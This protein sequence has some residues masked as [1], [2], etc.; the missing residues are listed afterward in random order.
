MY[1]PWTNR[2]FHGHQSGPRQWTRISDLEF[3]NSNFEVRNPQSAIR[4]SCLS[5][6]ELEALARALLSVLLSLFD[7]RI[8][9][10]QAGLL[11]SRAQVR[12]ELDQRPRDAVPDRARLPR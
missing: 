5:L 3:R 2:P 6:R 8:A 7:P 12:I 10:N 4:N 1:S 11:Q 9:C